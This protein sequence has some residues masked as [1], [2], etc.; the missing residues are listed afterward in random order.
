MLQLLDIQSG[1]PYWNEESHR[2][3]AVLLFK[4]CF[5][6]FFQNL[7]LVELDELAKHLRLTRSLPQPRCRPDSP[8]ILV[9]L[10]TIREF[11]RHTH[12][13]LQGRPLISDNATSGKAD[14]GG[15]MTF[16]GN[17]AVVCPTDHLRPLLPMLMREI[18]ADQIIF[19]P[20]EAR[21]RFLVAMECCFGIH[22]KDALLLG[23]GNGVDSGSPGYLTETSLVRFVG[24]AFYS[25]GDSFC[26]SLLEIPLPTFIKSLIKAAFLNL[27]EKGKIRDQFDVNFHELY[28]KWI[29]TLVENRDSGLT[30]RQTTFIWTYDYAALEKALVQ[31]S[32]L[33]LLRGR[34]LYGSRGRC[35]YICQ[36]GESLCRAHGRILGEVLKL[37]GVDSEINTDLPSPS[38]FVLHGTPCAPFEEWVAVFRRTVETAKSFNEVLVC[39]ELLLRIMGKRRSA[40]HPNPAHFV[41]LQPGPMLLFSDKPWIAGQFHHIPCTLELDDVLRE[42]GRIF[43]RSPVVLYQEEDRWVPSD[44]CSDSVVQNLSRPSGCTLQP[45]RNS[46]LNALVKMDLPEI[47]VD[48]LVGQNSGGNSP[49]SG[50]YSVAGNEIHQAASEAIA[51]LFMETGLQAALKQFLIEL[52][53]I[54]KVPGSQPFKGADLDRFCYSIPKKPSIATGPIPLTHEEDILAWALF[55]GLSRRHRGYNPRASRSAGELYVTLALEAAIPAVHLERFK[56]YFTL[57]NFVSTGE[58]EM[59]LC[60]F[61]TEDQGGLAWFPSSLTGEF[62]T[63]RIAKCIFQWRNSDYTRRLKKRAVHL[64]PFKFVKRSDVAKVVVKA[65]GRAGIRQKVDEASAWRLLCRVTELRSRMVHAGPVWGTAVGLLNGGLN[66]VK[67]EDCLR[68]MG[69]RDPMVSLD[70]LPWADVFQPVRPPLRAK[71]CQKWLAQA[72]GDGKE[73]FL[74]DV[75]KDLATWFNESNLSPSLNTFREWASTFCEVTRNGNQAAPN[76]IGRKAMEVCREKG[77]LLT[78]EAVQLISEEQ[79]RQAYLKLPSVIERTRPK[80]NTKSNVMPFEQ[81]ELSKQQL[82]VATAAVFLSG[83]RPSQARVLPP[84]VE[85]AGNLRFPMKFTKDGKYEARYAD[86]NFLS[87]IAETEISH[88]KIRRQAKLKGFASSPICKDSLVRCINKS[89]GCDVSPYDVRRYVIVR[90]LLRVSRMMTKAKGGG[91]VR[92]AALSWQVGHSRLTVAPSSYAGTALCLLSTRISNLRLVPTNQASKFTTVSQK[93]AIEG[94]V[95]SR[96]KALEHAV[97]IRRL[98]RAARS[99]L[100]HQRPTG[101][102][103][104]SKEPLIYLES[105]PSLLHLDDTVTTWVDLPIGPA[106]DALLSTISALLEYGRRKGFDL[107]IRL[108]RSADFPMGAAKA[109]SLCSFLRIEMVGRGV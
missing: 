43:S 26:P 53:R 101:N 109:H 5:V 16:E 94:I 49:L 48:Y 15:K 81:R 105:D 10:T 108:I 52:K 1:F 62:G 86:S 100:V 36:S 50:V 29:L 2:Q 104:T 87:P 6:L 76:V 34:P 72:S 102:D 41:R 65:I 30:S 27:S 9:S 96:Q 107:G 91:V 63:M 24:G 3:E 98:A 67:L 45:A 74:H 61:P 80:A 44:Q 79:F 78:S 93:D 57:G 47:V 70:G 83:M 95:P 58:A 38:P 32:V 14:S 17:L 11:I 20:E 7:D 77:W 103:N 39:I 28:A 55:E 60:P 88:R 89:F 37:S 18:V 54:P 99:Y 25:S 22:H 68:E 51:S 85:I 66:H 35:A 31:P 23:C 12:Q 71:T 40:I 59:V 21:Y 84:P 46:F 64:A 33:S 106:V 13:F 69:V 4:R 97:S 8:A 73:K 42:I 92:L 56:N 19:S 90:S 75:G 82:S